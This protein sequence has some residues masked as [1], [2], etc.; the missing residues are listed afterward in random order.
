MFINYR[1]LRETEVSHHT[2]LIFFRVVNIC[3][4]VSKSLDITSVTTHE[5]CLSLGTDLSVFYECG[6]SSRLKMLDTCQT[7]AEILNIRTLRSTDSCLSLHC[8][9]SS[10]V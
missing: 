2:N 10:Q 5:S 3:N 1:I 9:G 6:N 4:T 7:L 8:S